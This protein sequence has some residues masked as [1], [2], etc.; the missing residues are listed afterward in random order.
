MKKLLILLTFCVLSVSQATSS[1]QLHAI[2][3][4]KGVLKSYRVITWSG[5]DQSMVITP[6]TISEAQTKFGALL[7][8][9]TSGTSGTPDRL[10]LNYDDAGGLV[11]AEFQVTSGS[12]EKV[13]VK[14]EAIPNTAK[15]TAGTAKTDVE[16][17]TGKDIGGGEIKPPKE[18]APIE[19]DK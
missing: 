4:D 18:E 19:V 6:Y 5:P 16:T 3:D 13:T 17:K 2:K 7:N 8:K 11:S 1:I 9:T 15:V 14:G 10:I 12:F